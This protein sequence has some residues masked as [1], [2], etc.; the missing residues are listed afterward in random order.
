MAFLNPD[1]FSIR[2]RAT[3]H[4]RSKFDSPTTCTPITT[5][6]NTTNQ[7]NLSLQSVLEAI[8]SDELARLR[9]GV[10]LAADTYSCY[11]KRSDLPDNPLRD[12]ILPDGGA[13]HA[14]VRALEERASGALWDA[15]HREMEDKDIR[16]DP[17]SK[18]KC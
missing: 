5:D 18:F 16:T 2:L 10:N 6:D 11:K 17:V 4:E 1:D 14:L 3:D 7:G 12:G 15:C 9:R 8:S 13:A